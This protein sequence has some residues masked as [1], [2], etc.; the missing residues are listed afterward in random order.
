MV[1][2]NLWQYTPED[3][4]STLLDNGTPIQEDLPLC[5]NTSLVKT[6]K[7][8]LWTMLEGTGTAGELNSLLKMV[9]RANLKLRDPFTPWVLEHK[10]KLMSTKARKIL[11]KSGWNI[12]TLVNGF[13]NSQLALRALWGMRGIDRIIYLDSKSYISGDINALAR[14]P[15]EGVKLAAPL[16]YDGSWT[17]YFSTSTMVLSPSESTVSR[18]NRMSS[19]MRKGTSFE[20][21]INEIYPSRWYDLG[22]RFSVNTDF[23][24]K[25]PDYLKY[26]SAHFRIITFQS[27]PWDVCVCYC[28]LNFCTLITYK[29]SI[30]TESYLRTSNM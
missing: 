30:K 23:I 27:A 4:A 28:L 9:R 7:L 26:K 13:N 2:V 14:M 16:K 5:A 24:L 11:L 10:D 3:R 20:T 8:T 6:Q 15:L 22:Y 12:C 18:L 29:Y 25:N 21:F 17:T 1:G 19:Q